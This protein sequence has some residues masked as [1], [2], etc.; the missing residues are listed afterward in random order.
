MIKLSKG[1][2][3]PEIVEETLDIYSTLK[4]NA[5]E[6]FARYKDNVKWFKGEKGIMYPAGRKEWQ[7]ETIANIIE[8]NIRTIV[9]VL[10]DA[11]PI[12]RVK[13]FPLIEPTPDFEQTIRRFSEANDNAL[14]HIWRVNNLHEHL[15]KN[16]LN[17]C[18]KGLMVERFYWDS[19]KYG[20][21]GEVGAEVVAPDNILFDPKVPAINLEDGSCDWFIYFCYKPLTWFRYFFPD[22][23]VEPTKDNI[24]E[25]SNVEMGLYIEAYK[26]EYEVE[27]TKATTGEKVITKVKAKYP[28]GR[29]III[30]TKTLLDDSPVDVF[31]FAVEPIS[32]QI[33]SLFGC[34]DVTRQIELQKEFNMKLNQL[35]LNI[36][37][38]SNRQA[39]GTADCGLD[40]DIYAE[41]ADEPGY[42]F[43]LDFGKTLEDFHKGFEILQSQ[44]VQPELFQFVWTIMEFS[45]KVTGVTK[46]IQG[47]ASKKERQTG[48]EIGKML[49]TATL[50]FRERAAHIENFIRQMGLICMQFVSK[51]YTEPRPVW[52]VDSRT[53]E[54]V[55][56]RYEFPRTKNK[57]T[58]EEEPIDWEYDIEVQPDS[59][60]PVDLNSLADIAMRLKERGVI[61]NTELLRRIHLPHWEALPDQIPGQTAQGGAPPPVG[62]QGGRE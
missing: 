20:G 4:S 15:R 40:P 3:L 53:G 58:G 6:R 24:D 35:S 5:Q 52:S 59:T 10:T 32:D 36:A 7:S 26:S 22:K 21:L 16:V 34:D 30:G 49:E 12:M 55:I 8:S 42:M 61:S 29:R 27:T 62:V 38:A 43:L 45:E 57:I 28:K 44:N 41:H 17:G 39:V 47:L 54:M 11:K 25:K 23:E 18:I 51:Y 9:A 37:L 31:P 50:R 56:G 48:F 1:N 19:S 46:L 2:K 33:E 13:A 14:N 60:L